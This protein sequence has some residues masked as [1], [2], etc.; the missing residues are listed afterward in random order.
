MIST[1]GT[2]PFFFQIGVS[3]PIYD[4]LSRA[5]QIQQARAAEDDAHQAVRSRELAV[6]AQVAAAYRGVVAAYQKIGLQAANKAAAAEA[7]DL[8]Q[9]QYRVGS[10]SYLQ[11][12]DA[13]NTADQADANYVG[14][15]Y[16]YHRAIATLENAVGRPLR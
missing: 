14:A 4:G 5:T 15:V 10:G 9:Q 7:L 2:S 1:S 3:I 6:R 11:F 12:L 13:R 16:D 8:A